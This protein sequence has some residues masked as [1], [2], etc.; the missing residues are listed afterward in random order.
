MAFSQYDPHITL[1]KLRFDK[2]HQYLE[3]KGI[4]EK[5]IKPTKIANEL[6][7]MLNADGGILVLGISDNG[8]I[9]DLHM[10]NEEIL[11]QYRKL[12]FDF[13][14]PSASI[15]LEEKI[16]DTWELLFLYHV[17]QD[18][19][20]V[21]LRKDNEDVYLRISDSNKW[22]LDRDQVRKLEYDKTIR[23]FEDEERPDFDPEDFWT[24]V[25]DFYRK[26]LGFEGN[27]EQLLLS[28]HLAVKQKDGNIVY[29]NSAI[30]LFAEDP[31]KYIPSASLRYIRYDGIKQKTGASFNVIKD[32]SIIGCI[33][34][35]IEISKK[36]LSIALRDYYF[37]DIQEW[38]FIRTSEYPEEAWLEGI[39]NALCH[40]SYNLQWN[41][42][43]IKHYDDRL[44]I[45]NSGPL[46][47]QV[48]VDNIRTTRYAR[49]PRIAR[50]L[51]E[52]GYVRELNEWASRIFDTMKQ[53]LLPEPIYQDKD[54]TV[55]LILKNKI[56]NH[57]AT[58][59]EDTMRRIETIWMDMSPTEKLIVQYL[60][61]NYR[62]TIWEIMSSIA[63]TEP[64]IR[65]GFNK[66]IE[67]N[68]IMRHSEKVRDKH[69]IYTF[70][71]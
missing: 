9:E 3:R 52:M 53:L 70:K 5:W 71:K 8:D 33:P 14:T 11:D 67:Q 34:R 39:V 37:F 28:R 55:T 35:I 42:V 29:K 59:P 30:L 12:A 61:A 17:D 43:Y 50:V 36:F 22:P 65:T 7:G 47:A 54:N 31:E 56:A 2:E 63:K 23:K 19:E 69:A 66:L 25:L 16:L 45:S 13:I 18:Y 41:R 38:K 68:I 51:T 44:E 57:D 40:R 49:N 27:Y 58:I 60:F 6:I 24:S 21:F 48:T 10:L 26:R 20:R 32:E 4:H 15:C 1:E 62:W 46:P 64:A